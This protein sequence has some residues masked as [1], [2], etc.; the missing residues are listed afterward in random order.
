LTLDDALSRNKAMLQMVVDNIPAQIAYYD[1][2][3]ITCVFAN[4]AYASANGKSAQWAVGKH[5]REIIGEP[6]W[7]A[8]GPH[9]ERV[10]GGE[11]I[12]YERMLNA[13][14]GTERRIEVNLLPHFASSGEQVGAFVLIHDITRHYKAEQAVRDS[15]ERLRKFASATTEAIVFHKDGVIEDCNEAL[16]VL[17]GRSRESLLGINLLD[18]LPPAER[19][20]AQEHIREGLERTY[21]TAVFHDLGHVIPVES[22]SKRLNFN[23]Q[24]LRMVVARDI[25]EQHELRERL[26]KALQQSEAILATTAVGVCILSER[27]HQWVN[28]TLCAM[29]GYS[30]EALLGQDTRMYHASDESYAS[31]GL[32]AYADIDQLGSC[33][34]EAPMVRQDGSKIWVQIDG[35]A[36]DGEPGKQHSV[37]TYLDITQRKTAETDL[38]LMLLK[39]RELGE[40]KTRFVSMA[41]HEFR[42]PLSTIQTS[43]DLLSHYA[44]RL[45]PQERSETTTSIQQSVDRMRGLMENFLTLG[46]MGVSAAGCN[47]QACDLRAVLEQAATHVLSAN[48][49]R[50]SIVLETTGSDASVRLM[51]DKDLLDQIVGNLLTNACKYSA[52]NTTVTLRWGH[53]AKGSIQSLQIE[54]KDE[55]MG[56]PEADLPLLFETFHRASNV[57]GI[58]GSGLGLAIVKRAVQAHGGRLDVASQLGVGSCFTVRLPW[59]AAPA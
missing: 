54:V 37:W 14:D 22:T 21:Q 6:A 45:S 39:E 3:T 27:K 31:L 58:Q 8:I 5:C 16:G 47:L 19:D 32:K 24:E 57:V 42:T 10:I 55:G 20:I 53:V 51:L 9:V 59:Q 11:T 23:G 41:S 25:S 43:V 7:G 29:L 1:R 28:A 44:D 34:L 50:H 46:S 13:R 40:L 36:L 52:A 26:A 15:E 12:S 4:E 49:Q 2:D 33:T 18:F 56:I 35:R 17:V 38:Q 48:G 30:R